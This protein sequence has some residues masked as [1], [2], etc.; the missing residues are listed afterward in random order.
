MIVPVCETVLLPRWESTESLTITIMAVGPPVT[1][2]TVHQ[3][4]LAMGATTVCKSSNNER[5][6][7]AM[8]FCMI[9]MIE[10]PVSSDKYASAIGIACMIANRAHGL[11]LACFENRIAVDST[12]YCH[13]VYFVASPFPL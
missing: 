9:A 11:S 7:N 8:S 13:T 10:M 6:W 1:I 4:P 2:S 5:S 3:G 12:F